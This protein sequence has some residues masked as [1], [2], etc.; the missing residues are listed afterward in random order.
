MDR[1]KHVMRIYPFRDGHKFKAFRQLR[2]KV[3]QAVHSEIYALFGQRLF[4][5]LG[6]HALDADLRECDVENLVARGLDDF[7]LDPMA[8]LAK[9]CRNIIGLPKRQLRA[10]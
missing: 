10:A 2:R 7:E 4:D 8:T 5:L 3:F 1:Q 6:E 9:K